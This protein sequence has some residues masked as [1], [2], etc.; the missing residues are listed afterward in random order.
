MCVHVEGKV[1]VDICVHSVVMGWLGSV[2]SI[3]SKVF[4][5]EVKGL[6]EICWDLLIF[7]DIC[8]YLL[9]YVDICWHLLIFVEICW[10]M[11]RFVDICWHLLRFVDICW[12]L[13]IFVE[14]C[15]YLLTFV[16]ICWHLLIFV[17]ICW[18]SVGSR[19]YPHHPGLCAVVRACPCLGSVFQG[20]VHKCLHSVA[21]R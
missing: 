11:L 9:T 4:F 17:E 6:V 8:W 21:S 20:L 19:S 10:D 3:K 15:W 1:L 18:D 16:D 13:L 5:A 2:G 7:V 14:I 12:D